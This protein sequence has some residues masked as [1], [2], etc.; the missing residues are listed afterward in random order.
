MVAIN[1]YNRHSSKQQKNNIEQS[2][3]GEVNSAWFLSV[4]LPL[5]PSDLLHTPSWRILCQGLNLGCI[6]PSTSSRWMTL[7]FIDNF[8]FGSLR[9]VWPG[10]I[11]PFER[12]FFL[13]SLEENPDV[14]LITTSTVPLPWRGEHSLASADVTSLMVL[15]SLKISLHPLSMEHIH[16]L[17]L[18][19]DIPLHNSNMYMTTDYKTLSRASGVGARSFIHRCTVLCCSLWWLWNCKLPHSDHI[20]WN[21]TVSMKFI[22]LPLSRRSVLPANLT[23]SSLINYW[24]H[25]AVTPSVLYHLL[26]RPLR[27]ALFRMARTKQKKSDSSFHTSLLLKNI[28][29]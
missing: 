11:F 9:N 25:Y 24:F 28:A 14:T 26:Q 6:L 21:M 3:Y 15:D 13:T 29:P 22:L 27:S 19:F 8:L 23:V 12:Y 17:N 2:D 5:H 20:Q 18:T 4:L 7:D 1:I 16:R 10:L